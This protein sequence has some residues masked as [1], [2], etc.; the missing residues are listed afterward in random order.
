MMH[1]E[2]SVD[3]AAPVQRIYELAQDVAAWP[4]ILPH[5]R[6]VKVL[7]ENGR[8][9]E[10]EMAARRDWIPV[11]WTA[12]QTLDPSTPRIEFKHLSGWTKGMSVAWTFAP[13]AGGTRVTIAHDLD[14]HVRP[15]LRGWFGH[16]VVGDFF[17]QSIAGRT[18]ARMKQLAEERNG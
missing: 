17:I 11:R 9:R 3:V 4:A 1:L 16:R 13:C 7:R 12:L 10:V 14:E 8:E 6:W 15:M 18:L 5:Y 2:R